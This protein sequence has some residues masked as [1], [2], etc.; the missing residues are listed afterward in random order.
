MRKARKALS[1][2]RPY[3]MAEFSRK[4]KV[5]LDLNEST[6]GCSPKVME[7]IRKLSPQD[8]SA[9]PEQAT[10]KESIARYVG[11]LP[12]NIALTN[13]A[14][15][16]IRSIMNAYLEK[17]DE[18]V[19]P[20]PTFSVFELFAKV[21]DARVVQVPYNDDLSFPLEGLLSAISPNTKL[22]VIVNPN[23]PTGNSIGRED[24]IKVLDTA[25]DSMV[26]LDET[27]H[28]FA[29]MSHA[30][31]VKEHD[32]L[33]VLQTFSKAFGLAGLRTGYVISARQNIE[34]LQK[35]LPPFP[36]NSIAT[37]ACVTALEDLAFVDM[38]VAGVDREKRFMV[39]AYG[40][41]GLEAPMTDTNFLLVR[42]GG[43]ADM[44]QRALLA[45]GILVKNLGDSPHVKGCLRIAIGRHEENIAL[46][47]ALREILPPE[48][49]I[50]DMDG[51]LVDV[52]PSY[53]MT[54]K[55]AAEHF[56]GKEVTMEEIEGYKLKGGY[57]NDWDLTEAM[58][59]ARGKKV[60]KAEIVR[61]FQEIYVGKCYDGLISKERL[62]VSPDVLERLRDR[63]KL[64]IVTGRPRDEA[65]HTLRKFKIRDMFGSVVA[66]EDVKGREKPDPHGIQMSMKA[67]GVKRAVYLGDNIDDIKA[68]K[69][70]G[71]VPIGVIF[72][73]DVEGIKRKFA[74]LGAKEIL[75]SVND[76][77]EVLK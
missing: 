3:R 31:L 73:K 35:V 7:T 8:I 41:L 48:A 18:V 52:S 44:A 20:V 58:V 43:N 47:E 19:E 10:L 26:I 39:D 33:M 61:K 50:F 74:A 59:L 76:I 55:L 68:A 70:A 2:I 75:M 40:A 71:I 27:Y 30:A 66:L 60:P 5:R 21:N 77:V 34:D 6:M 23:S 53:R 37:Q 51:V 32:N 67:L 49:V 64:A 57:N 72:G 4:D 69:A 36:V 14:D 46:V 13:G 1:E 12:E 16:G 22:V 62:L 9:Y 28:H 42:F 15:E 45:K 24:I 56:I 29:K 65:E 17:G 38:V 11:L 25:K 54:M 63:F